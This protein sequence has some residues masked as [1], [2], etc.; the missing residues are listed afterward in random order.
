[1]RSVIARLAE[2][3]PPQV[4]AGLLLLRLWFGL[5]LALAHGLGKVSDLEA[6]TSQVAHM[7]V[8]GAELLAPLAALAEF[9]GGLLVAAGLLTRPAALAVLINML[10]AALVIHLD[11]PYSKKE[12]ALA[13]GMVALTLVATGPGRISLDRLLARSREARD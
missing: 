7:G 1:M 6:F 13:Y 10:V 11:D 9:M 12:F 8:N 3:T 4:D 5:N 2:T